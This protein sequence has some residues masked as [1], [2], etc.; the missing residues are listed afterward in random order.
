MKKLYIL[1]IG[2]SV[3]TFKNKKAP[4]IRKKLLSQI[5]QNIAKA[6]KEKN[7]DLIIVHG[8]GSI[9]HQIAK[10]YQL[11]KG[12]NSTPKGW[13]GSIQC[14]LAN[15]KHDLEI[16]QI[17]IK[18]QL[19]ISSIHTASII[20]QKNKLI[21]TI[22][23]NTISEAISK[24]CIPMLYGEMV[25]DEKLGMTICS[26]DAIVPYLAKQLNA[27]KIFYA[28]D[29]DGVFDADPYQNKRAA[30][31][32]EVCLSNISNLAKL[33]SSHNLDVTGGLAGKINNLSFLLNSKTKN[34]EIFNGLHPENYYKIL[35]NQN[36]SHTSIYLK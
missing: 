17:F 18:N 13:S 16:A 22:F 29:I 3:T 28:S 27:D 35:S 8:A 5:S 25:F 32:N 26:G 20:I 6:K 19:Q 33:S 9:G 4:G 23:L 1:K 21:K 10:K 31:I 34:A 14:Q 11:S 36:F 15:Q 24:N 30:I 12:A 7:F 2:G